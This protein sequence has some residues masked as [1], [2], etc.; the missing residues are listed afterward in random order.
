MDLLNNLISQKAHLSDSISNRPD[1][2][3]NNSFT[4]RYYTVYKNYRRAFDVYLIRKLPLYLYDEKIA[5]S[6]LRFMGVAPQ[7]MDYYQ[8]I[9]TMGLHY[10]FLRNNI[11]IEKLTLSDTDFFADLDDSDLQIISEEI[12]A[13]IDASFRSVIDFCESGVT[14]IESYGPDI[15][16]FWLDS[17][18]LVLGF[19][20]DDFADNGLGEEDEWLE[21]NFKQTSYLVDVLEQLSREAGEILQMKVNVLWY[22]EYTIDEPITLI[23]N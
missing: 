1:L 19:R 7:D 10:L 15:E 8:F 3:Q 11:F 12:L 13:R 18:E 17:D 4:E 21:N 23:G 20:F 16:R 5:G 2:F 6:G 14:G 9:S 22:N